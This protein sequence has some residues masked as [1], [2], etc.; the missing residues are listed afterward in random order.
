MWLTDLREFDYSCVIAK[1]ETICFGHVTI[2]F[3][4]HS[5]QYDT[6]RG[7]FVILGWKAETYNP[8]LWSGAPH[9]TCYLGLRNNHWRPF[10]SF[11]VQCFCVEFPHFIE[12]CWLL[13]VSICCSFLTITKDRTV[14]YLSSFPW[15]Y[16]GMYHQP[17][18]TDALEL[19]WIISPLIISWWKS[20]HGFN[21][22]I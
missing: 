20:V 14:S 16:R 5:S 9:S 18:F 21:S 17:K 3:T 19:W 8:G 2:C 13:S 10:Q 22:I 7:T 12:I 11:H 4:M 15:A 6:F 1:G